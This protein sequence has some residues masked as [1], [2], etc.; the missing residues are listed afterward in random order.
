[1]ALTNSNPEYHYSCLPLCV[2]DAVFSIGAR[3]TSTK[4]TVRRFREYLNLLLP[5]EV[6]PLTSEQLSISDLIKKYDEL[7]V[8]Q[9]AD[10]VYQNRQRTSTN[11]GI[12]KAEAVL[13]F[14]KV[15]IQYGVNY[16]QD[17]DKIIRNEDFEIEI[18]KIP[19]QR[20]KISTYYF[21]MLV[22]N[23]N[24]IKPDRMVER[25]IASAIGHKLN[26]EESVSALQQAQRIL[27]KDFPGLTPRTL[28]S[29]I[30]NYQR[31]K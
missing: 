2:V 16:L 20:S 27:V 14:A 28:D 21:Y 4:N 22:G 8:E 19:G 17:V 18:A 1:M 7:G 13:M 9:M 26:E 15:L 10:Q 6:L 29:I 30:W 25:F 24:Y 3:Y 5:C 31:G 11:N 12:L 23:E